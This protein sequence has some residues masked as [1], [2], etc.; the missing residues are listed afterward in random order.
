MDETSANQS[1]FLLIDFVTR[2]RVFFNRSG[3][4]P[5]KWH[6]RAPSRHSVFL[7]V[8]EN[9]CCESR[10]T[11]VALYTCTYY[12]AFRVQSTW[13]SKGDTRGELC[14]KPHDMQAKPRKPYAQTY[15]VFK[16]W[17]TNGFSEIVTHRW[18]NISENTA[19]FWYVL[20]MSASSK[21]R[22][23]CASNRW[24]WLT[25]PARCSCTF[26]RFFSSS[27]VFLCNGIFNYFLR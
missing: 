20:L 21:K 18:I 4:P 1:S 5:D 2:T 27:F 6:G 26:Q 10:F 14:Q 25:F 19:S 16:H 13:G 3:F 17:L 24:I 8:V 9:V 22:M 7:H 23:R 11:G 12:C 15:V